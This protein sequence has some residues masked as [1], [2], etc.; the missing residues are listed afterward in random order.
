MTDTDQE[1]E[2]EVLKRMLKSSP[3]PKRTPQH[4]VLLD[5]AMLVADVLERKGGSM[6]ADLYRNASDFRAGL[7]MERAVKLVE[8]QLSPAQ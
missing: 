1:R 2:D 4:Y 7:A 6:T 5:G 8:D 3:N